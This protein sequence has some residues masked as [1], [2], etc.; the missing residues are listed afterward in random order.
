[1]DYMQHIRLTQNTSARTTKALVI[2]IPS[3]A[4]FMDAA[5]KLDVLHVH[6]CVRETRATVKHSAIDGL[7]KLVCLVEVAVSV[8][9][10]SGVCVRWT[11]CANVCVPLFI[12]LC[13]RVYVEDAEGRLVGVVSIRD[14]CG[15][16]LAR[17]EDAT[18]K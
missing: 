8:D 17:F 15:E 14:V 6:R 7:H 1:M 2:A 11:D 3:T 4:T 9:G 10:C 13:F 12:V 16:V 18:R 5:T